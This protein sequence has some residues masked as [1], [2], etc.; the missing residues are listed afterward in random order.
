[1]SRRRISRRAAVTATLAAAAA[2]GAVTAAP[3]AA[4]PLTGESFSGGPA[5]V[6]A[7]CSSP[8]SV[9][10]TF[11]YHAAGS[12]AG[13]YNGTFTEDGTVTTDESENLTSLTA[14]FTINST[15]PPATV[16]GEKHMDAA[17]FGFGACAVPGEEQASDAN[18]TFSY[19]A[20]TPDCDDHGLTVLFTGPDAFSETFTSEGCVSTSKK[21]TKATDK[22]DRQCTKH[23]TGSKPCDKAEEK[24]GTSCG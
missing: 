9:A 13:P 2:L 19:T 20:Q 7:N 5:A 15:S 1:M 16:T 4:V 6:T 8:G 10:G 3:A 21:C 18:G 12:A 24:Q 22:A 11:T 23:G 14:T 17:S